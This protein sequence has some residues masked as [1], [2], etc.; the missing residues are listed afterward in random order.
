MTEFVRT[1]KTVVSYKALIPE[2][3]ESLRAYN[4]E[5][6]GEMGADKLAGPEV[7]P[8]PVVDL[9]T[10]PVQPVMVRPIRL[11]LAEDAVMKEEFEDFKNRVIAA[12]KHLG[13]DPKVLPL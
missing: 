13:L 9:K 6:P 1:E 12:F 7:T 4:E 2:T 5:V 8:E 3:A 10:I 11:V